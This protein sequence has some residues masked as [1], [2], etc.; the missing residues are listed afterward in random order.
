MFKDW[1][2]FPRGKDIW[3][4]WIDGWK[5]GM[6]VWAVGNAGLLSQD[7]WPQGTLSVPVG[8]QGLN[9]PTRR[10]GMETGCSQKV[11]PA[12]RMANPFSSQVILHGNALS[13]ALSVL[14]GGWRHQLGPPASATS[15][16][17][18]G[19]RPVHPL[20]TP[21]IYITYIYMYIKTLC[22]NPWHK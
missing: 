20:L 15:L 6:F 7:W 8:L 17:C 5:I 2:V 22:V 13:C 10:A 12:S 21:S 18:K 4:S 14:P 19:F 11:R 16:P 1:K 9:I 3:C